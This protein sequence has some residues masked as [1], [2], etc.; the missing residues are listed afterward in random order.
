MDPVTEAQ[1]ALLEAIKKAAQQ[2]HA[3][4]AQHYAEAYAWVTCPDNSH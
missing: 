3:E 2:G 4:Q 1:T